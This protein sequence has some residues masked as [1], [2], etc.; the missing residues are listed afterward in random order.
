MTIEATIECDECGNMEELS[1]T[2][3]REI[4]ELGWKEDPDNDGQH[5][6]PNCWKQRK[7]HDAQV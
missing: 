7:S 1:T 5:L 2:T 3:K 6:C 4:R